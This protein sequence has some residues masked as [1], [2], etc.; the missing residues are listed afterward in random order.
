MNILIITGHP[1][2]VHNFKYVKWEL[3]KKGHQVFWAATHK[4]ISEYLLKQYEIAYFTLKKPGKGFFSKFSTLFINAWALY[5]FNKKHKIDLILSRVSPYGSLAAKFQKIP[6]LAL[7]DTESS[8][9]YNSYFANM[10]TEFITGQ[11]FKLQ[12]REDQV[13]FN[14][15]I[16]MFY[17]H[18]DIF[19][20]WP[21]NKVEELL[22]LEPGEPFSI[23]RFVSWEAYHDKGLTGFT[24]ENKKKAVET[25]SKYGRVFITSEA[26]LNKDLEP[27]SIKIAPEMIHQVMDHASLFFGESATM[28]SESAILGVSVIYLNDN[29]LGYTDEAQEFGL[30]HSFKNN[31]Q[32]QS[33]AIAK[34]EEFL[35]AGIDSF[36]SKQ[37]RFMA[38]RDNPVD[39]L[40]ERIENYQK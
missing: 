26:G 31:P 19:E 23:L 32:S 29:W 37:E 2:Q 8:G 5:R 39:F 16:E 11:S 35:K 17:L 21:R 13:R 36:K 33:D 3:E 24:E 22:G 20:P 27:Y 34:G 10:V 4:E 14:G 6:H 28:A 12:L 18:P 15:N 1:A 38:N 40:I 7:A 9:V 25:F 30:L